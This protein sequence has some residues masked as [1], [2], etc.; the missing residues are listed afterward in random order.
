MVN[1]LEFSAYSSF[2]TKFGVCFL[3]DYALH[4]LDSETNFNVYYGQEMLEVVQRQS[5]NGKLTKAKPVNKS[6]KVGKSKGGFGRK[7]QG[8]V[9]DYDEED[10]YYSEA[11][12]YGGSGGP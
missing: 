2:I 6:H 8:M 5:S 3:P 11:L 7:E 1:C 10:D 4:Y 12:D 9:Y